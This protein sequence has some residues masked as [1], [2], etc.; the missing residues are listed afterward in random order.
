[1]FNILDSQNILKLD[2]TGHSFSRGCKTHIKQAITAAFFAVSSCHFMSNS[3]MLTTH[4]TSWRAQSVTK[5]VPCNSFPAAPP[6]DMGCTSNKWT[7]PKLQTS[8][9]QGDQNFTHLRNKMRRDQAS[10]WKQHRAF[11]HLGSLELALQ[12]GLFRET[13][14]HRNW[15]QQDRL[16]TLVSFFQTLFG[17]S[18]LFCYHTI[19]IPTDSFKDSS[20]AIE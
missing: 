1:M 9:G 7:R 17:E 13:K 18:F 20:V 12:M 14:Q 6:L 16:Q 10:W 2:W 15:W 3:M 5:W 19:V 11:L 4:L 8:K